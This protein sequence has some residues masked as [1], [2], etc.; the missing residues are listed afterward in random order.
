MPH[1][2]IVVLHFTTCLLR[3]TIAS[4][5]GCVLVMYVRGLREHSDFIGLLGDGPCGRPFLPGSGYLG[6]KLDP[7]PL[8]SNQI[9]L[10][11]A[12]GQLLKK[13]ADI[14]ILP[15]QPQS[16]RLCSFWNYLIRSI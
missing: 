14:S 9:T 4:K 2:T 12:E 3:P 5:H 11:I 10:S 15:P 1:V 16:L 13:N 6:D 7:P 8:I